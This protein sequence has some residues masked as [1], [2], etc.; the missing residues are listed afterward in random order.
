MVV[1]A[2]I[3]GPSGPISS[4]SRNQRSTVRSNR[5]SA[6]EEGDVH[7][8]LVVVARAAGGGRDARRSVRVPGTR[9]EA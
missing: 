5:A 1:D 7:A 8:L 2:E 3:G 9:E 6:S 4:I